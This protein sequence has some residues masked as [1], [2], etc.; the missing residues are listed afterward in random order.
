MPRE[1]RPIANPYIVGNPIEDPR[2]FFGREDDFSYIKQK[3][4]GQ[5]KGGLFVL[6]GGRRSGKTSILFQVKRGRLGER[7]LPVLIDMQSI[8]V[9]NDA[10]FLAKLA[11]EVAA[12]AASPDLDFTTDY[13]QAAQANP[14]LAL[15]DFVAKAVAVTGGRKL[16]LMFDEYE[17]FESLFDSGKLTL[18]ILRR[19]ASLIESDH[20]VFIIFTGSEKLNARAPRYW[21]EFLPKAQHRH[22]SFLSESDAMRLIHEPLK[23]LAEYAE[24]VSA[25]IFALECTKTP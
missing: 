9:R 12:A 15:T 23:G 3:T 6:C 18:N 7:F 24:G 4:T 25:R 14:E 11:K 5:E 22:I 20:G 19:L 2:M 17:L 8:T 13:E 21:K 1:F 10:E 16:L